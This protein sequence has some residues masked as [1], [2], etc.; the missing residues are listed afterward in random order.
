MLHADY[1]HVGELVPALTG[2]TPVAVGA[3]TINDLVKRASVEAKT[4][5]YLCVA[6]APSVDGYTSYGAALT[7]NGVKKTVPCPAPTAILADNRVIGSA[8]LPMIAAGY[9]DLAAKIVAGA[10]WHIAATLG[11]KLGTVRSRI[12][13]GRALLRAAL[14]HR[15]PTPQP[16]A[17]GGRTLATGRLAPAGVS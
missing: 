8:P 13:R 15:A 11:I 9:A 14:S 16:V 7:V 5:G 10:D 6:T 3:G 1:T 17:A 2:R 4:P 12:H